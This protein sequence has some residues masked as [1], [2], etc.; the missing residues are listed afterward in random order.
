MPAHSNIKSNLEY[1]SLMGNRTPNLKAITPV[2][3]SNV[4]LSQIVPN[5]GSPN[6][7]KGYYI[8]QNIKN[9]SPYFMDPSTITV[10]RNMYARSSFR[11][12]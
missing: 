5:C 6:D 3:T 12:G 7:R 11:C 8:G 4:I 2:M 9:G 10:A 1:I